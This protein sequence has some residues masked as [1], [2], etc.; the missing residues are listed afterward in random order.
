MANGPQQLSERA[1]TPPNQAHPGAAFTADLVKALNRLLV[2]ALLELGNSGRDDNA[3]RIAGEGWSL[4][5]H[6]EPRE[7]E[8]LNGVLHSLTRSQCR[9]NQKTQPRGD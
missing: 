1:L 8:R 9:S 6:T 2:R 7:A 5:R 3:C 4:L